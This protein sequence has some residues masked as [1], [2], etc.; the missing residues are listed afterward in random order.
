MGLSELIDKT[1]LQQ[2]HEV[3][4]NKLSAINTT[5]SSHSSQIASKQADQ[6]IFDSNFIEAVVKAHTNGVTEFQANNNNDIYTGLQRAA[7]PIGSWSSFFDG[8]KNDRDIKILIANPNFGDKNNHQDA[9]KK[10]SSEY[11]TVQSV[12]KNTTFTY[13]SN[14]KI[15]DTGYLCFMWIG[16]PYQDGPVL[17]QLKIGKKCYIELSIIPIGTQKTIYIKSDVLDNIVAGMTTVRPI[18]MTS[19]IYDSLNSSLL[20]AGL[21]IQW[22]EFWDFITNTKNNLSLFPDNTFFKFALLKPY[23]VFKTKLGGK[24]NPMIALPEIIHVTNIITSFDSS[25][26]SDRVSLVLQ[27]T[28]SSAISTGERN[29]IFSLL[30]GRSSS[31]NT[32][33]LSKKVALYCNDTVYDIE[34][35]KDT[36]L[37]LSGGTLSGLLRANG[38]VSVDSDGSNNTYI[39]SSNI[40]L[41]QSSSVYAQIDNTGVAKCINGSSSTPIKTITAATT[42]NSTNAATTAFVQNLINSKDIQANAINKTYAEL[43]NLKGS[44]VPGTFYRITNYQA[45]SK[46]SLTS[47]NTSAAFDIIVLAISTDQLS[48]TAYAVKRSNTTYYN[49][50]NLS[51][52]ELKYSLANDENRFAWATSSG[53][54][55]IYYMKDEYGNEAPYD[56]KGILFLRYKAKISSSANYNDSGFFTSYTSYNTGSSQALVSYPILWSS[57]SLDSGYLSY[58]SVSPLTSAYCYTFS[59]LKQDNPSLVNFPPSVYDAS[60]LKYQT[61]RG[62]RYGNNKI[63]PFYE[64]GKLTLNNIVIFNEINNTTNDG[65]SY[66]NTFA[67]N[68]FKIT[69]CAGCYQNHFGDGCYNIIFGNSCQFNMIGCLS[70]DVIFSN[71]NTDIVLGSNNHDIYLGKNGHHSEIKQNCGWIRIGKDFQFSTVYAGCAYIT[72]GSGT[73]YANQFVA[74]E[75]GA[76]CAYLNVYIKGST[77]SSVVGCRLRP[78]VRGTSST[79]RKNVQFTNNSDTYS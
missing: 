67:P 55:V 18:D 71:D 52:W 12:S 28:F 45:S 21:N 68:C 35:I 22:S 44:Y 26:Y 79:S 78:N 3:I 10:V 38:C 70:R 73:T 37:P 46:T 1:A 9:I 72:I 30:L 29:I 76:Y 6:I 43:V 56:F 47:V 48:E 58:N 23:T 77:T 36:Y 60:I 74:S 15:I 66:S 50:C 65:Y 4:K 20:D 54:G 34:N 11:I 42:D 13:T 19:S 27:G 41:K 53:R 17:Y 59:Y 49:N 33:N 51:A 31:E 16:L 75:I 24:T 57:S 2:Y 40:Q 62:Y 5:L 63:E 61:S 7:T 14:D 39:T 69:L 25:Y 8:F 64:S 32:A